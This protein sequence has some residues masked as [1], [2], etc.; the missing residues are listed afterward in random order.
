[1]LATA[2][3]LKHAQ[4]ECRPAAEV[5][6]ARAHPD[7][8][9]Y[10]DPPYP[11]GTRSASGKGR[12]QYA[13]EMSDADHAEL[14]AVLRAHPGPVLLSGYACPLYDEALAD[15]ARVS[16]R[17][18]TEHGGEREEVLW[19]NPAAASAGEGRLW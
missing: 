6:A 2:E 11:L 18:L 14:L 15:W 8:L 16:T 4:I 7:V 5:L 19:S 1:V 10:A 9:V 13:R 12:K 3:R 17:A